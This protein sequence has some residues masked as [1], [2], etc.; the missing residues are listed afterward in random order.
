MYL[1]STGWSVGAEAG[2]FPEDV[3]IPIGEGNRWLVMQMHYYNPT[4]IKDV[5]DSNGL[6]LFITK[7]LRPIGGGIMQFVVGTETCTLIEIS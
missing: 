3:G 6:R 7:D 4:M 5:Y 1:C 2:G